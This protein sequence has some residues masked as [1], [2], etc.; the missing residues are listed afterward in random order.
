MCPLIDSKTGEQ[1]ACL[2]AAKL[3]LISA[4]T[5][6]KAGGKDD[7]LTML[8][9]GKEKDDLAA[10]MTEIA[11]TRNNPGFHRDA[12]NVKDS[13]AVVLI[14]VQGTKGFGLNCGACGFAD[15]NEFNQAPKK[16]GL[17]FIGPNCLFKEL[18]LG[19]ALGSAAKTASVLNLDNR[20]MYRIG[21]AVFDLNWMPTAS[22][23]HGIPISITGKSIYFDR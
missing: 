10:Q 6:P 15:C 3:M 22:V 4:R 21:P 13:D 16:K 17:D 23:I 14:G 20:I 1:D 8:V 7:I 19:I 9:Y 18:D 12:K 11:E 2:E 5:A